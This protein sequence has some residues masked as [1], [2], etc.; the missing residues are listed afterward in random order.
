MATA[1]VAVA[2]RS[3]ISHLMSNDAVRSESAVH[4]V[5]ERH[6]QRKLLARLVRRG[7]IVETGPDRYY[8]DMPAYDRWRRRLRR[9]MALLMGGV[10]LVAVLAGVF[11]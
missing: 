11:A 5:P 1:A 10:G 3:V 8:L 6:L 9:R 4:Y 7:V 2:I